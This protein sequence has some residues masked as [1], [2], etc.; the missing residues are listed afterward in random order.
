MFQ[1]GLDS[2]SNSQPQKLKMVLQQ[3]PHHHSSRIMLCGPQHCHLRHNLYFSSSYARIPVCMI[4]TMFPIHSPIKWMLNKLKTLNLKYDWWKSRPCGFWWGGGGTVEL[5]TKLMN[6]NSGKTPGY[7]LFLLFFVNIFRVNENVICMFSHS[8]VPPTQRH[9]ALSSGIRTVVLR[10]DHGQVLALHLWGMWRECKP[11]PNDGRMQQLLQPR[12]TLGTGRDHSHHDSFQPGSL[13]G[14]SRPWSVPIDEKCLVLW[15]G[16]EAVSSVQLRR[17]SWKSE[18]VRNGGGM[19]A[20]LRSG[21]HHIDHTCTSC[22]PIDHTC[23]SSFHC[24][25]HTCNCQWHQDNAE[26]HCY[27]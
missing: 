1:S 5:L 25:D 24:T 6:S 27:N 23:T 8:Q 12:D 21:C 13:L 17:M 2:L 18:P 26:E 11:V 15:H 22:H 7:F 14:G 16:Q 4:W 9:R 3:H 10:H 20:D 19:Q